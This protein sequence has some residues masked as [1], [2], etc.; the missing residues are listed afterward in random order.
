MSLADA[1][2]GMEPKR[3][4]EAPPKKGQHAKTPNLS[5]EARKRIA[6]AIKRRWKERVQE[7]K[8]PGTAVPKRSSAQVPK[9]LHAAGPKNSGTRAPSRGLSVESPRLP[10][11]GTAKSRHPEFEA[12]KVYVRKATHKAARRKFEDAGEGDFSELVEKLLSKY[13]GT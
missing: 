9:A 3:S 10:L 13:L 5:A 4:A 8:R 11:Q 7:L 1:F 12:V 6:E 2:N